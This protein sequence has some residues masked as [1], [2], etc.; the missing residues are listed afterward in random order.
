MPGGIGG[1]FSKE[2]V[3]S[4]PLGPRVG[5]PCFF[6]TRDIVGRHLGWLGGDVRA[7]YGGLPDDLA[8]LYAAGLH[9]VGTILIRKRRKL[10][11]MVLVEYTKIYCFNKLFKFLLSKFAS[12][13]FF[14]Y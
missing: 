2:E 5:H 11:F 6:K 13:L 12:L 9:F 7:S 8:P 14:Y 3:S 1:I 4:V 10:H